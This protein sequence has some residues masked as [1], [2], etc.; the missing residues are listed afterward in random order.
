MADHPAQ[1]GGVPAAFAGFDFRV[2]AGWGDDAVDRLLT[3]AA[4]VR[5]RGKIASVLHNARR[6]VALVDEAGSL[7]AHVAAY[8][9]SRPRPRTRAEIPAV[10]PASVALARDLRRRGWTY[11][12]PTTAYAFLQAMGLVDDHLAG[13]AI[14]W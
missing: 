14:T 3:D 9:T 13:C 11:V 5:H 12:G 1:T 8:A 4:I 2:L 7:H 10:T 6:A